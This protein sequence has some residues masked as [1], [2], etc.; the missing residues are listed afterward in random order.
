MLRD[1]LPSTWAVFLG[2]LASERAAV[3]AAAQAVGLADEHLLEFDS[4]AAQLVQTER[5]TV[6]ER[7]LG[8]LRDRLHPES[9]ID[10]PERAS[11]R[12]WVAARPEDDGQG[13]L[14]IHSTAVDVAGMYDTI[15][16]GAVAAHG[17]QDECR[18][19]GQLMTDIAVDLILQGAAG[20]APDPG[21]PAYPMERIGSP[22]VPHRRAIDA[23]VLV[24]MSAETATGAGNAPAEVAGL[25]SIDADVARRLV[26]HGRTWTRVVTDPVDSA[27]LAIDTHERYTPTAL[28]KLIHLRAPTCVGDD[29]GLP[30][31]RVDLDHVTR[32]EHD[33]RTRHINLQPLCRRVHQI[34]DEGYV[35]VSLHADGTVR[36]H[37]RWGATRTVPPALA[38]KVD[39]VARPTSLDQEECP[40]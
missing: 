5:T 18:T 1:R 17:R 37:T 33:G 22:R 24:V 35:D 10:R 20:V 11:A 7:R 27:V 26:Q 16:Q 14:E 23:T 29:C 6:I 2:G 4:M 36:W 19:L 34:K 9:T 15:R 13:V 40:F 3:A 8:L 31:H 12:R 30:A 25:G 38:I 39:A 21:D 32:F 28:K